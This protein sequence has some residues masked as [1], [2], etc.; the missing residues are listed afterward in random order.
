MQELGADRVL[1]HCHVSEKFRGAA[2]NACN[3]YMKQ[4]EPIPVYF[5]NFRG[6]DS[7]LIM[8]TTGK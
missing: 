7:H 2:N 4:K 1:N 3:L 8:Q 6:Y 5:H